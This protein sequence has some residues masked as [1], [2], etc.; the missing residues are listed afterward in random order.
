MVKIVETVRGFVVEFGSVNEFADYFIYEY[1]DFRVNGNKIRIKNVAVS[2]DLDDQL[3]L[4]ICF[5]FIDAKNISNEYKCKFICAV[6]RESGI[7][8]VDDR[9][10]EYTSKSRFFWAYLSLIPPFTIIA[11]FVFKW[12]NKLKIAY[13]SVGNFESPEDKLIRKMKVHEGTQKFGR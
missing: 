7:A 13:K 8:W 5:Q 3:R 11:P 10:L 6:L 4:G 9:L 1:I 12:A 2:P